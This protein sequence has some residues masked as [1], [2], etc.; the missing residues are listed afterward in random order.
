MKDLSDEKLILKYK[1]LGDVDSLNLLFSRY[2]NRTYIYFLR[3]FN[4]RDDAEDMTQNL[5]IKLFRKIN[6]GEEIKNFR[7]YIYR[8]CVNLCRDYF[9]QKKS[10]R[11]IQCLND[12]E[13][14]HSINLISV[15]NWQQSGER[16]FISLSEIENAIK[17]CL[18]KFKPTRNRNI[19]KDYVYGYSL[20]EIAQR[21]N[22]RTGT[23]GSI[24]HR[25]KRKLMECVL[26]TI[27][28]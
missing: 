2:L 27:G 18:A 23:A 4:N 21:N 20:K 24:W 8:S 28:E 13:C 10:A 25:Q 7:D 5:F 16:H 14:L 26:E 12:F 6:S 1:K 22:C 11:E 9:R 17:N 15:L 3:K 19:L